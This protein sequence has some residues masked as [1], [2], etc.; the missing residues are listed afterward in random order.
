MDEWLYGGAQPPTLWGKG[1]PIKKGALLFA[2]S[3]SS[4]PSIQQSI[5]P[6]IHMVEAQFHLNSLYGFEVVVEVAI[7]CFRLFIAML[8]LRLPNNWLTLSVV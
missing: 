7:H 6:L 2:L 4:L 1:R 3:L 8:R 5:N